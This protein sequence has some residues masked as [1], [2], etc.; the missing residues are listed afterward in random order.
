MER[1]R[2]ALLPRAQYLLS[3][4]GQQITVHLPRAQVERQ[5]AS[6]DEFGNV[7][8]PPPPAPAAQGVVVTGYAYQLDE[9]ARREYGDGAASINT[10]LWLAFL[11]FE[12]PVGTPGFRLT[13]SDGPGLTPVGDANDL[14]NAHVIWQVLCAAAEARGA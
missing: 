13:L 11:P 8:Q 5:P 7:A 4:Y 6:V 12:A 3:N 9:K 10:P 1:A 2:A 14:A